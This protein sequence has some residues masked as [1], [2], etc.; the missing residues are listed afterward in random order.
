[1]S[2][3]MFSPTVLLPKDFQPCHTSVKQVAFPSELIEEEPLD[4]G[5]GLFCPRLDPLLDL[6]APVRVQE[7]GPISKQKHK[8][9]RKEQLSDLL[10]SQVVRGSVYIMS[11]YR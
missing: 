10:L 5:R 9:E 11:R 2:S 6:S 8:R 7:V 3:M 1:M 4:V